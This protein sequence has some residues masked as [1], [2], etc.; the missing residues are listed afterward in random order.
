VKAASTGPGRDGAHIQHQHLIEIVGDGRQIV[1]DDDHAAPLPGQP[2]QERDD[3]AL[4]GSIDAG[5]RLVEDQEVG[6]L[7]Q[8]T[9]QEDALLLAAGQLP[10]LPV[11][12]RRHI[13]LAETVH[14]ELPLAWTDQLQSAEA[15]IEP[16]QDDIDDGRR[17]VPVDAG[18]LRHIGD[19]GAHRVERLAEKS[20]IAGDR[21]H[22]THRSLEQ[23]RFSRAVRPDDGAHLPGCELHIDRRK[24]RLIAIGNGKPGNGERRFG[25]I[26]LERTRQHQ[27][28]NSLP[29]MPPSGAVPPSARV[30]VRRVAVDH[31]DI[32]AAIGAGRSH[33]IG[34]ELATDRNLMAAGGGT[35]HERPDI[36]LRYRAF[37][38]DRGDPT[39]DDQRHQPINLLQTRFALRGEALDAEHFEIVSLAEIAESVMGRDQH[40]LVR[41]HRL[42]ALAGIGG[43]VLDLFEIGR[44]V[45]FIRGGALGID[46]GEC[47]SRAF[48]HGRPQG[49]VHPDMGIV[50]VGIGGA[51]DALADRN[52]FA[53]RHD[54]LLAG[55]PSQELLKLGLE[56]KSVPEHDIGAHHGGDVGLR[57]AVKVR[58]D[59]LAHQ[60]VDIGAIARHAGDGVAQHRHGGDDL[61]ALRRL[62]LVGKRP[63]PAEPSAAIPPGELQ[64][65]LPVRDR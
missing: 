14:R 64:R 43:N 22:H 21:R 16:H 51:F 18:A 30:I 2:A 35:F 13:D 56:I 8:C 26:R 46:L 40:A 9:C 25:C 34:I 23:R 57:L 48:H 53:Q 59:A 41:R 31:A 49:R 7:D 55:Q 54:R 3:R 44:R 50:A 32:G 37:D 19:A 24:R 5:K 47:V 39:I 11:G 4:G 52:C 12:K 6:L 1:V 62:R 28:S 42:Q 65:W 61:Q 33:G 63:G 10:D 45:G 27:L 29:A 20:D 60:R 17:E 15:G 38:E 58:I 36:A